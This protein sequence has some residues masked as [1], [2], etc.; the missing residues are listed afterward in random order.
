MGLLRP[1]NPHVRVGGWGG[2]CRP[3]NLQLWGGGDAADVQST[4]VGHSEQ[5]TSSGDSCGCVQGLAELKWPGYTVL[6][7]CYEPESLGEEYR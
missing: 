3:G 5:L 2:G 6:S 1:G 7:P 4:A